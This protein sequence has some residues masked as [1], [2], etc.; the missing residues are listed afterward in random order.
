MNA[1]LS[2]QTEKDPKKIQLVN[3]QHAMTVYKIEKDLHTTCTIQHSQF[4]N[5]L[6][7]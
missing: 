4:S 2:S 3:D 6:K 5:E 7:K 1:R